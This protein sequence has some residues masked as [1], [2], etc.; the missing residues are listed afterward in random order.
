MKRYLL[1]GLIILLLPMMFALEINAKDSYKQGETFLATISGNFLEPILT[2]NVFL[3]RDHVRVP[4]EISTAEI[5]GEYYIYAT[6][7]EKSAG[8]Y[9][10]RI[11]DSSYLNGR[12]VI[13]EDIIINFSITDETCDFSILPGFIS[14][15]K[16]FQI[17][18]QNLKENKISLSIEDDGSSDIFTATSAYS[19]KSGEIKKIDFVVPEVQSSSLKTIT[20]STTD[21]SYSLPVYLIAVNQDNST[22]EK[23]YEFGPS[24]F[25][26]NLSTDSNKT[27][28]TY[29]E[30]IGETDLENITLDISDEIAPYISLSFYD[31][32]ILEK[33]DSVK[34]EIYVSTPSNEISIA[35]QIKAKDVSG[36]YAYL[37][38]E[39]NTLKN[40]I[41]PKNTTSP[42]S[43][44]NTTLIDEESTSSSGKI[45]GWIIILILLGIVGWFFFKKYKGTK[46]LK[47]NLLD[48]IKKKSKPEIKER[49]ILINNNRKFP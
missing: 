21:Y 41:P 30:N 19:I 33:N 5:D 6:L 45:I 47:F 8:N 20:F 34:L 42:S 43:P 11:E 37:P 4:S 24:Y 29:L 10:I 40:Y 23:E 1:A 38:F 25:N 2:Q 31:L 48:I 32:E 15:S 16:D 3:Y 39:L 18:V 26:L 44:T 17:S 36:V 7:L 9:S 22:K 35:G 49:E 28:I 13:D 12:D 46:Y 27:Y 14:T